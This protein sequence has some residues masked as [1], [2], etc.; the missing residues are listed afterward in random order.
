MNKHLGLRR[1]Q[2]IC[3][4]FNLEFYMTPFHADI[5]NDYF[6]YVKCSSYKRIDVRFYRSGIIVVYIYNKKHVI[7]NILRGKSL[8]SYEIYQYIDAYLNERTKI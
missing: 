8:K 4:R 5:F 1:V 7:H 6:L 2:Q 3:K